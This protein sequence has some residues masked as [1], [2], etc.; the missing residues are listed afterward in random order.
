MA[1]PDKKKRRAEREELASLAATMSLDFLDQLVDFV[2][3]ENMIL[4]RRS[5]K[6]LTTLLDNFDMEDFESNID[7]QARFRSEE[8]RV[9]KEC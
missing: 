1:P 4:T 7:R 9:G 3:A 2:F 8:R 6:Q 5:F